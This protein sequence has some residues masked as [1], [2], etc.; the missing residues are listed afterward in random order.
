MTAWLEGGIVDSV[1]SELVV[2]FLAKKGWSDKNFQ[3][4]QLIMQ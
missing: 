4:R 2:R 1:E 3:V